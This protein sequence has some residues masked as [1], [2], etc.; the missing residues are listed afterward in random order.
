MG[1]SRSS[2]NVRGAA[3]DTIGRDLDKLISHYNSYHGGLR[4]T[5]DERLKT[6]SKVESY[7][8]AGRQ[9]VNVLVQDHALTK[10]ESRQMLKMLDKAEE[11]VQPLSFTQSGWKHKKRSK[12]RNVVIPDVWL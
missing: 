7:V 1:R 10:A 9:I 12:S 8:D 2:R 3:L 11:S 6:Q 4:K 5:A